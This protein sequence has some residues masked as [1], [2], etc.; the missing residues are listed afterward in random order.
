MLELVL[1]RESESGAHRFNCNSALDHDLHTEAASFHF[2]VNSAVAVNH[3]IGSGNLLDQL[4]IVEIIVKRID[5]SLD[6]LGIIAI[7][8]CDLAKL[9]LVVYYVYKHCN[10]DRYECRAKSDGRN[11]A[12]R[13]LDGRGKK[14]EKRLSEQH[15][16]GNKQAYKQNKIKLSVISLSLR[17]DLSET[18]LAVTSSDYTAG[19]LKIGNDG[20]IVGLFLAYAGFSNPIIL[21]KISLYTTLT[22]LCASDFRSLLHL[23]FPPL[24]LHRNRIRFLFP[25]R[26]PQAYRKPERGYNRPIPRAY[27]FPL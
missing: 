7:S 18:S 12:R 23:R 22:F 16:K 9:A 21:Y 3:D 15:C 10:G 27:R 25:R 26:K 1:N 24:S 11:N 5:N 6:G 2:V 8:L 19:V 17:R 20:I 14:I 4:P 13:R